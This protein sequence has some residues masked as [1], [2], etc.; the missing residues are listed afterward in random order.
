MGRGIKG[1]AEKLS[2]T[3]E[4]RELNLLCLQNAGQQRG[5]QASAAM[6]CPS[7]APQRDSPPQQYSKTEG[8]RRGEK[9]K[10][11]GNFYMQKD[12]L[13]YAFFKKYF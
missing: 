12:R 6:G 1:Q 7:C 4:E 5:L 10:T 11:S 2:V 3:K 13:L 8:C 9:G